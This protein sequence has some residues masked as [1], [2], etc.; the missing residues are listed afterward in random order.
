[1]PVQLE[2]ED[3]LWTYLA[4]EVSAA[5]P[6]DATWPVPSEEGY[7]LERLGIRHPDNQSLVHDTLRYCWAGRAEGLSSDVRPPKPDTKGKTR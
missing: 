5:I 3:E 7:V 6:P 1:M 4:D 2:P